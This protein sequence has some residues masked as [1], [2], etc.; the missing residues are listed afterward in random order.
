MPSAE[1][2]INELP[3]RSARDEYTTR[4]SDSQRDVQRLDKRDA[5]FATMRGVTALFGMAILF[6]WYNGSLPIWW[7]AVPTVAFVAQMLL[8]DRVVDAL[9]AARRKCDHY[10]TGLSRLNDDWAGRGPAGERYE[11][12]EHDYASDLD[13]FGDGSLFQLLNAARTRLGKDRLARWLC[14]AADRETILKRQ[15]AVERLRH[16]VGLREQLALLDARV[17]EE[18]DQ[19]HLIDWAS[20]PAQTISGRARLVAVVL[21]GLALVAAFGF[22]FLGMGLSPFLLMLVVLLCFLFAFRTQIVASISQ[23]DEAG[24]ELE[25]LSQV[26]KVMEQEAFGDPWLDSVVARVRFCGEP[27]SRQVGRLAKNIQYLNNSTR[28]QFFLALGIVTCL[29]LHLV[30][31]IETWRATVG[32]EIPHWL[33]AVGDFESIV[34]LSRFAFERPANPFPDIAKVDPGLSATGLGHPLL[35]DSECVRNDVTLNSSTQQM[36]M[37][38]GSNMSGKS[39]LLRTIGIN[40]VLA[41]AGAPVCAERMTLYPMQVAAAMRISDSLQQGRSLFFSVLNRLKRVVDLA[42]QE[43]VLFLLDEILQG[44]NSHDRRIG[45]EAVIRSLIEHRAIGLVT[46]HDLALTEISGSL[47]GVVNVHFADQI[48]DGTMTFDYKL[49]PGTVQKSNAIELMRLVGLE[50]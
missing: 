33:S 16:E 37:V 40:C 48:Q 38:S 36:L 12:P 25:I 44:T 46:T 49:R 26:L 4:L 34:S 15:K 11:N 8:H 42:G 47:T 32:R 19:N 23:L 13:L 1:N 39:T 3:P 29:P 9:A 24:K 5:L 28:N 31:A 21:S 35:K 20:Q 41:Q 17:H 50:V 6:F 22:A 14:H 2:E 30:H 43:T 7:L 18:F 27:P 10:Q 45:A